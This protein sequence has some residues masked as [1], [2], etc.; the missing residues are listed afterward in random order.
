MPN[1]SAT[2]IAALGRPDELQ[3]F[4]NVVN[5]LPGRKEAAESDFGTWWLGNLVDALGGDWHNVP[6]RG[7]ISPDPEH[8]ATFFLTVPKDDWR[9]SYCGKGPLFFSV[10]MAWT[11]DHRLLD[12]FKEKF[13]SMDFRWK[14]T[15]EFGNFYERFDP[16]DTL[17]DVSYELD[18]DDGCSTFTID[19][20]EQF[21][22]ELRNH[23]GLEFSSEMSFSDI[24]DRFYEWTN[25]LPEDDVR[26]WDRLVIWTN[27]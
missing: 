16:D 14:S 24:L 27:V 8:P 11:L 15:D 9:L 7:V 6:C 4:V 12:F 23:T 19:E 21:L 22:T 26:R 1:W 5:S 2:R 10:V 20:S 3:A 17:D 25:S 13:P 18:T